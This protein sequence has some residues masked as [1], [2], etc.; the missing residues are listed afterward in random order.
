ML[1]TVKYIGKQTPFSSLLAG[2][3]VSNGAAAC[4]WPC[5][6]S[7]SFSRSRRR[8]EVGMKLRLTARLNY[9]EFFL[10]SCFRWCR[11]WYNFVF[12]AEEGLCWHYTE[13]QRPVG[14]SSNQLLL[15]VSIQ[16][17]MAASFFATNN[18]CCQC[19][20]NTNG[21]CAIENQR[22]AVHFMEVFSQL[23]RLHSDEL[24]TRTRFCRI[25]E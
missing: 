10:N 13:Y 4:T 21:Y 17:Q 7:W 8:L 11:S 25:C 2:S 22:C 5:I 18:S 16:W 9:I 3:A 15:L 23:P 24:Q 1:L 12:A 20:W 19:C 6:C 14:S